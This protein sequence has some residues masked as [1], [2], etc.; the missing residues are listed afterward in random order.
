MGMTPTPNSAKH[1]WD[2]TDT[3]LEDP[4]NY[5]RNKRLQQKRMNKRLEQQKWEATRKRMLAAGNRFTDPKMNE[6]YN[7]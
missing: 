4:G 1:P 2:L 7:L 5:Q 3:P 6:Y